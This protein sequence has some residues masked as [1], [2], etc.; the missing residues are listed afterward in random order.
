[1]SIPFSKTI[2]CAGLIGKHKS[3]E[4]AAALPQL[5]AFLRERG[6]RVLIEAGNAEKAG[7]EGA[8]AAS[9]EVMGREAD[10]AFV[11]GGD[12][13]MLYA[14]RRL[15]AFD[16]PLAGINQGR[17]GFMTDIARKDM[18]PA[19]GELLSGR[20]TAEP[21]MLLAGEVWRDGRRIH[22]ALALNEVVV[23]KGDLGRMIEVRV[24][25]NQ[26]FVYLSHA[27]GIIVT[28]PTG[29]TAYSLS[30]GGPILHPGLP[31]IAVV[32]L[33]PHALT[34]R[35]ITI[36]ADSRIDITLLSSI[37]GRA[38]FDGQDCYELHSGDRVRIARSPQTLTLLHPP[39]Y[40]YYAMLRGKLHWSEPPKR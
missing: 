31:G 13:T 24:E 34:T 39:G 25:V 3:A 21:R 22:D 29:S 37:S 14:A 15:A 28:T 8:E 20:F 26:E 2:R 11:L 33:F 23:S 10:V 40:S 9:Y 38:H 32:P 18:L 7:A 6:V 12:G 17:L 5:A 4:V 19:A 27:D 36:D 16:V 30:A 35:P 1:M